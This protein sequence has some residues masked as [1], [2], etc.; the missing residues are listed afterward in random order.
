[1]APIKLRQTK[2]YSLLE[3]SKMIGVSP[4]TLTKYIKRGRIKA[5]KISGKWFFEEVDLKDFVKSLPRKS[6]KKRGGMKK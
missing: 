4:L 2:L 1:M 6:K 3:V 5:S